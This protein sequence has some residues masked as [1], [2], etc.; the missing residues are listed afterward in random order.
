MQ[1]LQQEKTMAELQVLKSQV[2]PHFIFNTLNN[3]YSTALKT[4]SETAQLIA[5]LSSLLNYN[6]YEAQQDFVP[7]TAEITYLNH[8]IELQKNRYGSKLD[9]AVNIYDEIDDLSIT[10]LLLLPL[11]ENS[12]KHG[13]SASLARSWVRVDVAR[14]KNYFSVKIEN[15]IDENIEQDENKNGGIGISNV[16]KRLELV[17]PGAHEL[18]FARQPHS[19][20]AILK[21]KL[22]T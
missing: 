8:Y 22:S 12:F 7:L 1:S 5:H 20:L 3:I 15:S 18:K 9:A 10:P 13:V 2:Q 6:L 21:L 19:F 16:Q 17:Y 11:I 14:N 4:N